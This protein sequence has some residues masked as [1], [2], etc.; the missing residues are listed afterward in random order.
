MKVWNLFRWTLPIR[1]P[2]LQKLTLV[3]NK[4]VGWLMHSSVISTHYCWSLELIML[5]FCM[6]D[7]LILTV[8]TYTACI[9][10]VR[11]LICVSTLVIISITNSS[12]SL[13]TVLTLVRLF[14]CVDA[15]MNK[16]IASL[17]ELLMTMCALIVWSI[18]HWESC[19]SDI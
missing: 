15:D 9:A 17:I 3:G 11:L 6:F 2:I 14:T 13:T 16:Q 8:I 18:Y 10:T 1:N 12:E 4:N 5:W 7:K 19:V